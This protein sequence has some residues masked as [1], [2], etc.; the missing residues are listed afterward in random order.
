MTDEPNP[1]GPEPEDLPRRPI[2]AIE[3]AGLRKELTAALNR[4]S[5]ENASNT[6]DFI[7]AQYLSSCLDAFDAAT[8]LRDTWY[9]RTPKPG[10]S[11]LIPATMTTATPPLRQP[12]G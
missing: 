2:P 7:L 11:A 9:G 5:R 12:E 4:H 3:H 1:I 8:I 10:A 6:P